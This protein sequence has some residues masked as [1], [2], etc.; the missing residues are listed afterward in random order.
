MSDTAAFPLFYPTYQPFTGERWELRLAALVICPG[1]WSGPRM[2]E[3]MAALIRHDSG[4]TRAWMSMT[5]METESQEIGCQLASGRTVV[6]GM[7]MGWAAAN[8]ALNPA[9]TA[10]TVVEFDAEVLTAVEQ[11]GIFRQLPPEAAAKITI[12]QGDAHTWTPVDGRP[13]DTLLADIWLPLHGLDREAQVRTMA[14]NTGATR[15]YFWGQ[16]MNMAWRLKEL[17]LLVDAA[18]IARVVAEWGL[19]LLGPDQPNYAERAAAA[20]E[21]WLRAPE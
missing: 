11:S 18:G 19:P 2:V 5:P 4:N 20:A 9:V 3:N 6:M 7:G 10:V 14:A 12:H 17:G 1:Y 16:E 15:I 13:F 21:R 8:A